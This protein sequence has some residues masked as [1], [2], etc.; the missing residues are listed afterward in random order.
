MGFDMFSEPVRRAAMKTARDTGKPA[1]SGKVILA[2]ESK[3]P[4]P[5][6]IY[7]YPIFVRDQPVSTVEERRRAIMGFIFQLASRMK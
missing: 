4:V 3:D 1:V 2:G 7:Y 5:G 6:F